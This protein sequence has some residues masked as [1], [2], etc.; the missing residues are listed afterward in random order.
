MTRVA[1]IGTTSW[2]T[3]LAVLLSRNGADVTLCARS[4]EEAAALDADRESPRRPGLKFPESLTV[5]ADEGVLSGSDIVL[6]AVPSASLA[7]N[8]A[9]YAGAIGPAAGVLSAVKG[10]GPETGLRMTQLIAAAGIGETRLLALSGPN[11]AG[12]IAAGLPAATVV[13]G[14][15]PALTARV[16]TLLS[17]PAFR[18]Y[19][20]DDV[21]GVEL[22]GA[23]KNV[24]AIACGISDGLGYGENAKAAL[25]TRA[26]AEITRLGVAAGARPLTFLGL[27]GMGDLI[28]TCESDISR[29]RR[30]GLALAKGASL[31]E[32]SAGIEGV[33]EGAV[34]A[35]AVPVLA[36]KYGVELPICAALHAVLYE[37]LAPE[38]AVRELMSRASRAELYGLG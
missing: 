33:V 18:V 15:D 11:F 31:Q 8:L 5:S 19:T 21:A 2:G 34:T 28:L 24:V 20:S 9:R 26:L 30:L 23:L 13:A 36:R 27:A 1:V 16:Q 7:Q 17:G 35:R 10:I 25:I 4:S 38:R 22:G 37:G 3:T 12:E 14:S 29:N 6:I 32:A